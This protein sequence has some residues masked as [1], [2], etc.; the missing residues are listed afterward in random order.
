M[1]SV[2]CAGGGFF[3]CD[4]CRATVFMASTTETDDYKLKIKCS[5]PGPC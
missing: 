1:C 5:Q 4:A 3:A 2:Q